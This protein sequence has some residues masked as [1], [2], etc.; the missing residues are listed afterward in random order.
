MRTGYWVGFFL[1]CA[2]TAKAADVPYSF[3]Y[4]GVLRGGSGEMLAAGSKKVDFRLYES[5]GGGTP[6]WSREYMVQLDTNGLFNVELS[7]SGAVIQSDPPLASSTALN[8]V[9]AGHA[10]L[11]LG[12]TV[13]GSAEI[14]PRQQLLSVPFAMMA[15][16]VKSASNGFTVN[17]ELAVSSRVK[18]SGDVEAMNVTVGDASKNVTLS[19]SSLGCL[20]VQNLN[21]PGNITVVGNAAVTGNATVSNLTVT[22]TTTLSGPVQAFSPHKTSDPTICTFKD[23]EKTEQTILSS[24]YTDGFMVISV[25][26]YFDTDGSDGENKAYGDFKFTLGSNTRTARYGHHVENMDADTFHNVEI[27]TLPVRKGEK[28]SF[29]PDTNNWFKDSNSFTIEMT[30]TFVPFGVS[31]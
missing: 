6:L 12:L 17:G 23:S 16:D 8:A 28:I 5:A 27:I 11:Y 24:A 9:V 29:A 18:V 7:D 15:G 2:V 20:N 31:Q 14:A 3:N 22:G 4:Q 13:I 1:A 30:C 25:R 19:A 26:W 10:S 21:V